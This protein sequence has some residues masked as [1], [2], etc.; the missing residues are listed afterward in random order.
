MRPTNIY[1]IKLK[2]PHTCS[3]DP[4]LLYV[5]KISFTITGKEI[6]FTSLIKTLV[7]LLPTLA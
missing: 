7:P 6:I 4:F 3:L 5:Y 1:K 2:S